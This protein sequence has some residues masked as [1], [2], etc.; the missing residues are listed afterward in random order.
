ML[1]LIVDKPKPGLG[2]TNDGNTDRRFFRNPEL[3]ADITV[4]D[5]IL[6]KYFAIL[7]RS[8]FSSYDI[9]IKKFK[10][11]AQVP[12]HLYLKKKIFTLGITC[13]LLCTVQML[14]NQLCYQLGSILRKPRK[15][16]ILVNG[17]VLPRTKIYDVDH[18]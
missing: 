12:K 5:M 18:I 3:N 4:V 2:N 16:A 13:L 9:N 14:F 10:S 15:L 7:L 6:T 17:H 8:L 1:D 11:L